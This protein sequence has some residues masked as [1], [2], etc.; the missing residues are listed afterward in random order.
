MKYAQSKR[1]YRLLFLVA[2]IIVSIAT[3]QNV[4]G[5]WDKNLGRKLRESHRTEMRQREHERFPEILE[6]EGMEAARAYR[7]RPMVFGES[8]AM[9]LYSDWRWALVTIT[10]AGIFLA[11]YSLI[12]TAGNCCFRYVVYGSVKDLP[13][14]R[15]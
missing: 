12:W 5:W 14:I 15:E 10:F 4:S 13:N 1:L 9:R 8:K 6:E 7:L 3:Y 2:A 11:A